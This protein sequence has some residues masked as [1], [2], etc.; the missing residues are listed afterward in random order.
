MNKCVFIGNLTRDA[1]MRHTNRGTAL[2][3]F[4]VAVNERRKI[5]EE[6]KD[7]AHFFEFT[8]WGS[9]AEAVHQYLTKGT[10]VG[11]T[12]RAQLERWETDGNKRQKVTFTVEDLDLVGGNRDRNGGSNTGAY[13]ARNGDGYED[14]GEFQGDGFVDDIPF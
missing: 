12:A 10:K 6:W 14:R 8:M 1:E 9:R 2:M 7:V 3:K 5:G 13:G 11:V 4:S